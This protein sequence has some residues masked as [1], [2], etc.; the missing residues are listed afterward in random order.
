MPPIRIVLAVIAALVLA[1]AASASTLAPTGPN[2]MTFTGA[3]EHNN[4]KFNEQNGEYLLGSAEQPFTVDPICQARG[5]DGSYDVFSCPTSTTRVVAILGGPDEFDSSD[6]KSPYDNSFTVGSAP[7]SVSFD[8]RGGDG[9]DN[10]VVAGG[11][12]MVTGGKGADILIAGPADDT[13]IGGAG[14]ELASGGPGN[15]TIYTGD[16]GGSGRGVPES[17]VYHDAVNCGD[18]SDTVYAGPEDFVEPNCENVSIVKPKAG[19]QVVGN[20]PIAGLSRSGKQAR[21]KIHCNVQT[22]CAGKVTIRA[23]AKAIGS[24]AFSVPAGKDATVK[25]SLSAAARKTLRKKGKL[26]VRVFAAQG[27]KDP[28]PSE[29][30][31]TLH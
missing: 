15:D 5:N 1:P 17:P 28:L 4:F 29:R 16:R 6:P 22:T 31:F 3:A 14:G 9:A 13:L 8:V 23:G 27:S 26:K 25:V 7:A 21:V 12:A 20:V 10:V 30:S 11:L 19:T 2:E 24:K 18:G